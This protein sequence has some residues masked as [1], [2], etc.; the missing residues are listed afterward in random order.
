MTANSAEHSSVSEVEEEVCESGRCQGWAHLQNAS[1]W[2][3][4]LSYYFSQSMVLVQSGMCNQGCSLQLCNLYTKMPM[5]GS[6]QAE[7]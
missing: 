6:G 3:I 7:I 2:C 5:E 1:S 4:A